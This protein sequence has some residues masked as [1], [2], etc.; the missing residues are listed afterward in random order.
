MPAR[1]FNVRLPEN[2][3]EALFRHIKEQKKV[4][5]FLRAAIAEKLARDF[6]EKVEIAEMVRGTRNDMKTPEGKAAAEKNLRAARERRNVYASMRKEIENFFKNDFADA[7]KFGITC[8]HFWFKLVSGETY[9]FDYEIPSWMR[10]TQEQ[11]EK[12]LAAKGVDYELS[13]EEFLKSSE[14]MLNYW[15]R[16]LIDLEAEGKE[17]KSFGVGLGKYKAASRD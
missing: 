8:S 1:N 13:R 17:I 9:A 4:S 10:M 12:E 16:R 14:E 15:K 7:Q 3:Q 2:L 11:A 5:N 6:G